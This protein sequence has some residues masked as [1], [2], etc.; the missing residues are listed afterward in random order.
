MLEMSQSIS[1]NNMSSMTVVSWV[2]LKINYAI[3][4]HC[5]TLPDGGWG[6]ESLGGDK[7]C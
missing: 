4:S 2:M 1:H 3:T 5:K 7:A 6:E